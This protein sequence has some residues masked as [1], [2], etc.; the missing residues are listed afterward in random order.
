M[1]P[2]HDNYDDHHLHHPSPPPPPHKPLVLKDPSDVKPRPF[3][4]LSFVNGALKNHNDSVLPPWSGHRSSR[5]HR[6][7]VVYRECMKNHA[8]SLGGHAIDGCGEFMS[9][10]ASNQAA[11]ASLTCDA[12]G[13]HRNFHRRL[14]HGSGEGAHHRRHREGRGGDGPRDK[15]EEEEEVHTHSSSPPPPLSKPSAACNQYSSSAPNMFM[16]I[17]AGGQVA[18]S[19]VV[20]RKRFRSKFSAEQKARM[21]ELS[22]RLGWRMQ[23]RDE[24]LV[25]QSCQEIGVSRGVFKV[26]LHNNKHTFM[27]GPSSRRGSGGGAGAGGGVTEDTTSYGVER[28]S[29][30]GACVNGTT[31]CSTGGEHGGCGLVGNS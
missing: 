12:C 30:E 18:G 14:V 21:Q 25:E 7:Q 3:V 16:A 6:H 31:S 13:C 26:W 15:E 28:G 11:P 9:S 22:Q 10:P 2:H 8:A 4:P 19:S 29:A 20:P 1:D 23:K 5:G 24:A 27:G 17:S